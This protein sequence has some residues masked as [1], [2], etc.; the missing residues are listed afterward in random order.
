MCGYGSSLLSRSGDFSKLCELAGLA[1]GLESAR[2]LQIA[3]GRDGRW[4]PCWFV[5]S[6]TAI[7]NRGIISLGMPRAHFARQSPQALDSHFHN[8]DHTPWV[9]CHPVVALVLNADV[10]HSHPR[11]RRNTIPTRTGLQI[12]V[13]ERYFLKANGHRSTRPEKAND[14]EVVH[15]R[16]PCEIVSQCCA[17][18]SA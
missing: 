7:I 11:S 4:T 16:S 3:A 2:G 12:Q 9:R 15:A 18:S 6:F 10:C 5:E 14:Q 13:D 1:M 8:V 17:R